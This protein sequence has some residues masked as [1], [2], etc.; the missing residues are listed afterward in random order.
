LGEDG[1]TVIDPRSRMRYLSGHVSRALSVPTQDA[2]AADGRLSSD[3][4]L[5]RRRAGDP[6]RRVVS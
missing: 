5:A 6:L 4:E 3:E 2:F 1:L